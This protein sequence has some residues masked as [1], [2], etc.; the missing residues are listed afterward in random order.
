[1]LLFAFGRLFAAPHIDLANCG[2]PDTPIPFLLA[3]P[4]M[5]NLVTTHARWSFRPRF[6][7][8][9]LFI[10]MTVACLLGGYWMNRAIR[11]RTAVRRFYELTADR[12]SGPLGDLTTMGYRYQGKDQY[13]KPI[14]PQWLHPLRDMIGEEAFGE[15]TGVQLMSTPATNNDLRYL[16]DVPTVERISVDD[17]KV[18][19]EGLLHLRACSKLR[20]LGLNG[21]PITD[22][23][24][25]E[26]SDLAELDSISLNGTKITDAGLVHLEKLTK[27]KHL[28]LRNTAIT[29]A[30]YRKLQA[31][32][33]DCEIQADVPAY[34]EK[35][36]VL[37]W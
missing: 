22:K 18:T 25:A 21:I 37:H 32:L 9:T 7:L 8:Q 36:R 15:V 5:S 3:T 19:D 16:S 4:T 20:F 10:V 6:S 26:I 27:L 12:E 13:Y 23:G 31:A 28:W 30:G 34:T 17:T 35:Y 11:Q 33:P 29:D 1:L 14:T 24:L 2:E